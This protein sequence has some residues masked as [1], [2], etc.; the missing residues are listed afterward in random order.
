M[1]DEF[2][3]A[4]AEQLSGSRPRAAEAP[5]GDAGA[6]AAASAATASNA[7]SAAARN[8][9]FGERFRGWWKRVRSW[10]VGDGGTVR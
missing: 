8:K 1:A 5:A 6:S 7:A 10:F 3:S 4:F 2:F 9:P